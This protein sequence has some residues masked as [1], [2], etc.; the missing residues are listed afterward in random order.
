MRGPWLLQANEVQLT[1][2]PTGHR[3]DP[4]TLRRVQGHVD[5][6]GLE[7]YALLDLHPWWVDAQ[8]HRVQVEG[9]AWAR[10][11]RG[12]ALRRWLEGGEPGP[13]LAV[14]DSGGD[15]P[16]LA[17]AAERGGVGCLVANGALRDPAWPV[18]RGSYA[19]GVREAMLDWS[20]GY[21]LLL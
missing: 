1:L 17:L 12:S 15:A 9:A 8:P 3:F 5:A 7:G 10:P 6:S 2:K 21:A 20:H 18:P 14:G 11:D 13:I 16:M 4:E 19:D